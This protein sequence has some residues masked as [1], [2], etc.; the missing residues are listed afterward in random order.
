MFVLAPDAVADG[1]VT[2]R[3]PIATPAEVAGA[4]AVPPAIVEIPGFVRVAVVVVPV[5]AF[6][7][8]AAPTDDTVGVMRTGAVEP[9]TGVA[10]LPTLDAVGVVGVA[11]TL[12][13]VV[14]VIAPLA[15]LVV[16]ATVV[17]PTLA[18][19]AVPFDRALLMA[20]AV[21]TPDV[22]A[23]V[24]AAPAASIAT[25]P[26]SAPLMIAGVGGELID[27]LTVTCGLTASEGFCHC[28]VSGVC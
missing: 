22:A 10:P 20:L 1:F 18:G 17:A 5:A 11:V 21:V 23:A 13:A 6:T 7:T 9:A 16:P 19:A 14:P 8:G 12:P 26:P 24:S 27:E 15:M 3:A 2:G 4:A 28:P 25:P